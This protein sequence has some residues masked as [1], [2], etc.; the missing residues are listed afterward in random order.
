M[1]ADWGSDRDAG[2]LGE[3]IHIARAMTTVR[4]VGRLLGLILEK[5]RLVTG[6]DA[7][8]IYIVESH[9]EGSALRFKLTQNDSV[10]FDSSEFTIPLSER[11]VA[12]WVALHKAPLN[13][14]NV[15][16]LPAGS[17]FHF[18]P[19]FD[20]R[21][22]YVTRSMLAAPLISQR[23]EVIGVIQ[24]I[25]KKAGPEPQTIESDRRRRPRDG[26]R[27][28]QRRA[29]RAA[30]FASGGVARDGPALRGN[31]T[32]VRRLREGER[33]GN[34]VARSD[35]ER[36]FAACRRADG[37]TRAGSRPRIDRA[38]WPHGV[39]GRGP[40]RKSNTR[41]CCTT[42]ARSACAR[43]SSSRPESFTTTTC[44]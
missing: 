18:D 41:A 3:L 26:V 38:L 30:C 22:G 4:D 9:G 13:L 8:S 33:R 15:Y 29:A 25:N 39:Y 28:T 27:R 5:S 34:R 16:A 23:D 37:A 7:G 11:S 40:A 12:G 44:A 19:S 43:K 21:A 42:S 6:A 32:A 35:D 17:T 14:A 10:A 20:R 24:L 31:S 2:V 36:P 1:N